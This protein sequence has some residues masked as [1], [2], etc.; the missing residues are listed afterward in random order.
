MSNR[1]K[2]GGGGGGGHVLTHS[3]C[4]DDWSS[5]SGGELLVCVCLCACP[6]YARLLRRLRR[7][8]A[9]H[10]LNVT[11]MLNEREGGGAGGVEKL[12]KELLT[13]LCQRLYGTGAPVWQLEPVM[14][15]VAKGLLGIDGVDFILLQREGFAY[16]PERQ[17]TVTFRMTRSYC[18]HKFDELEVLAVRLA[19]LAS[20]TPC[21]STV[22]T[23]MVTEEMKDAALEIV[24]EEFI[25]EEDAD[26]KRRSGSSPHIIDR[27]WR[28]TSRLRHTASLA[29]SRLSFSMSPKSILTFTSNL[30]KSQT[31][32][33]RRRQQQDGEQKQKQ[34]HKRK[35]SNER[36][37]A[38]AAAA[39]S[40]TEIL[41]EQR[42]EAAAIIDL[43]AS[44]PGMFYYEDI[45]DPGD[46][47]WDAEPHIRALFS[48]L[49]AAQAIER[50]KAIDEVAD[51]AKYHRLVMLL[52]NVAASAGAAGFWYQGGWPDIAL[53]AALTIVVDLT[54]RRWSYLTRA[55]GERA[56]F[57]CFVAFLVGIT[58]GLIA[59]E[60][61]NEICFGAVGI[62]SLSSVFQ[63]FK[64]VFS[65]LQLMSKHSLAGTADLVEALLFTALIAYF[66]KFGQYIAA[67]IMSSPA[68]QFLGCDNPISQL[69]YILLVP[70]SALA[71]SV[72]FLPKYRDLPVMT[73]HGVASFAISWGLDQASNIGTF[74]SFFAASIVTF[75]AGIYSRFTGKHSVANTMAGLYVLVPGAYAVKSYFGIANTNLEGS[76]FTSQILATIV[77]RAVIIGLGAWT[78]MMMRMDFEIRCTPLSLSLSRRLLLCSR[79]HTYT[80]HISTWRYRLVTIRMT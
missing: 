69:Y 64:I 78:G 2:G 44:G 33:R 74:K 70:I 28:A 46:E 29:P 65:V 54:Q 19:S 39:V 79:I 1:L 34:N 24:E 63:G 66:L 73:L 47:A 35:E 61:P 77:T 21:V 8:D 50:I 71:W 43:A 25:R 36:S 32:R 3:V 5:R 23:A 26:E 75:S 49:A 59:I 10:V 15:R 42:I 51:D 48:Y 53:T 57:E 27:K 14:S 72:Q 30:T 45:G 56:V 52:A 58:A 17:T 7:F 20:N 11:A 6:Q 9:K 76:M 68:H 18:M 40:T 37:N 38:A 62:A 80:A 4:D 41:N 60:W 13:K 31:I 67:V 22:Q 12:G 16:F 55:I